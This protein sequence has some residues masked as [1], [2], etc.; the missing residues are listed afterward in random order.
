M[1]KLKGKLEKMRGKPERPRGQFIV[2]FII[3]RS[4][5]IEKA[6]AV[7][8][9][10][11]A[12]C[13]P[14]VQIN[15][16]LSK[17][18]PSDM[19]SKQGID[20]MEKEFG[21]PGTARVMISGVTIYEAKNYKDRIENIKGVDSVTW[22]D[23]VT[24]IYQSNMFV[25]YNDIDDYY[26]DGNAVM[27][28]VFTGN[29]SDPGTRSALNEMKTMLGDKGYF[30]GP[31]VQEKFLNEV[32]AKEMVSILVCGI[33]IIL[34]ILT[35]FSHSWFEPVVFLTVILISVVINMGTNLVFGS[36]S[37]ITFSVAAVLQLAVAMDYTIILLDNFTKERKREPDVEEALS[38]AIR[39]S[40]TAVSS[41]GA[42]AIVGFLV[43][44]LMRYSIG[45]DIGLVLAKGIAISLITVMLLTPAVILRTY[46]K[47]EKTQ[48]R[49]IIPS[50]KT[51]SE[52]IHRF[53]VPIAIILMLLTVPSFFGRS[54][55]DFTYGND[56]MG[57]SV[58]TK[59]YED[60]KKINSIFGRSNLVL[61]IVPNTSMVTEKKLSDELEALPYVKNV[62]SLANTIPQG[63]PENF[64]PEN[65][66]SKLHTKDFAR[67]LVPIRTANESELAFSSVEEI[68]K[69]ANRY[70]P[71]KAYVI[72][73]TPSTMDIRN[74]IAD[75]WT[76]I[77]KLSL[78]GVALAIMIAFR[79]LALP[80]I[81]VIPILMAIFINMMVPY[82][83]GDQIMFM[84]F[85]IV[86]CLQLGA[87]IDYSIV[88]TY[89]YLEHR[90]NEDKV[91]ASI[92]ATADSMPPILMS[93]LIL[94]VAGFGVYFLSSVTA[95][96]DL[97]ILIG[98]G[99]LLSML[100]VIALLPS[101][102]VWADKLIIK[103]SINLLH[104]NELQDVELKEGK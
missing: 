25:P 58:G 83:Q 32:L 94:S 7:I 51:T 86:S 16:D 4:R 65:L 46:K 104:E 2:D 88:M 13:F 100:M 23:S 41:A 92:K 70:Y 82:L 24:D 66:T 42:A 67:I 28:V 89:H 62:T 35:L 95:I 15:Y 18:L 12:I 20:L 31:A 74:V 84:G 27:D 10:I 97:G 87:T 78:L 98:R 36:I 43:L 102:F 61:L 73:A 75:D 80:F 54:M 44:V 34:A 45:R 71:E 19:Q 81:L 11:S 21:Y 90:K 60:D 77:E 39:K 49:Y 76:K 47:I 55:T 17:Y 40:I 59:V 56:A 96:S 50:F 29:N 14:F 101:L 64:L 79:S 63:V 53:R 85:I 30:S 9:I 99:A 48:H 69:I 5:L 26:K 103:S 57:L 38:R 8:F 91:T 52:K 1:L 6:F 3:H 22:A 37:S 72:G 33:L 68:T 93:G